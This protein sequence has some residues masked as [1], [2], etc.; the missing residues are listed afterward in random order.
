MSLADL[1]RDFGYNATAAAADDHTSS[2]DGPLP[3]AYQQAAVDGAL[4]R[5]ENVFVTGP[6]GS[7]KVRTT[8]TTTTTR[9]VIF[10][11]DAAISR[12]RCVTWWPARA[13]VASPCR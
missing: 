7:G 3:D 4:L 6:A 12:S 11:L 10:I 9:G 5:H 2:D 13:T 8:T 1:M